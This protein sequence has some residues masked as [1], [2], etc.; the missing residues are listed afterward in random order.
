MEIWRDF[1]SLSRYRLECLTSF[2]AFVSCEVQTQRL[3]RNKGNKLEE[4]QDGEEKRV[5]EELK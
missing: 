4:F 3:E 2:D 5:E 1:P